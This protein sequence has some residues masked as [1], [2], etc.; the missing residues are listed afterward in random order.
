MAERACIH[1]GLSGGVGPRELRPYGPNGSDVCAKCAFEG[2]PERLKEAER[3]LAARLCCSE[4]LVLVVE[5]QTGPRPIR[6][7]GTA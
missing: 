3:Q 5:E 2:P 7:K 6:F 1:C 4:P